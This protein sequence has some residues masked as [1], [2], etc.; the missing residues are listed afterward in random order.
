M[1]PI[2]AVPLLCT[3]S[4]TTGINAGWPHITG[5]RD[6]TLRSQG[7]YGTSSNASHNPDYTLTLSLVLTTPQLLLLTDVFPSLE[8]VYLPPEL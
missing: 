3:G 7:V 5:W 8:S 6:E 1:L 4:S 2:T